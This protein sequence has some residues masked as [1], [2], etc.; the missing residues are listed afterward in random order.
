ML[1]ASNQ[2]VQGNTCV[3][4]PAG[5]TNAAGD[6]APSRLSVAPRLCYELSDR[7]YLEGECLKSGMLKTYRLDRFRRIEA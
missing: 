6:D 5:S 2:R 4:C 7:G 3:A 1:C